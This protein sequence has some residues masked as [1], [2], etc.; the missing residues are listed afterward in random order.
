[1][2]DSERDEKIIAHYNCIDETVKRIKEIQD[3]RDKHR[4][5][6]EDKDQEYAD[7]LKATE[8]ELEDLTDSL[9][10]LE[11]EEAREQPRLGDWVVIKIN[12]GGL[13]GKTGK[14]TKVTNCQF[15]IKIPGIPDQVYRNKGNVRKL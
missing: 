10:K 4:Q 3:R 9:N 12:T 6:F 7:E 13:L 5:I 1:M 11:L 2:K 8:R 14:V 15:K